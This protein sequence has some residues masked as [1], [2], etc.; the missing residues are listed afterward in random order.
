[1][2]RLVP[3]TESEFQTY[4]E[5]AVQEYA[6]EHVKAGNWAAEEAL[7][8]SRKEI[9]S[10]L[11]DG[12]ASKD[13]YLFTIQDSDSGAKVG[14]IWFAVMQRGGMPFA[15]IYDFNIYG[16]FQRRGYAT[17][18]LRALE[19]QVKALNIN[20]IELHVFG[21]NH[22][23]RSLYEKSGYEVMDLRMIKKVS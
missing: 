2:V 13:Q 21:H 4:Y 7:D 19:E 8:N 6:D 1:M 17:L 18:A 9:D 14:M 11:Q 20:E 3:M 22:A 15:F 10:L 5:H 16:A 12:V 23:A